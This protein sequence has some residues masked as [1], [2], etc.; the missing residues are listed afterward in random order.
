MSKKDYAERDAL[1]E[2]AAQLIGALVRIDGSTV[3][4]LSDQFPWM[5]ALNDVDRAT[6]ADRIVA[7]AR[8]SISTKQPRLAISELVAWRETATA[9]AA[10]LG[11]ET[12]DWFGESEPA[13]R[14]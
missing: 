9:M 11:S 12:V 5:L 13:E 6:C 1:L 8:A 3:D 10:G 14:P 2:L 4:R 7:A